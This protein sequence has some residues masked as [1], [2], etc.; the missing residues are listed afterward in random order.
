[1][2][3]LSVETAALLAILYQDRLA[4]RYPADMVSRA[5]ELHRQI[6]CVKDASP[7]CHYKRKKP[8]PV[9]RERRTLRA[10]ITN[11]RKLALASSL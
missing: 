1:M 11:G 9:F 7:R 5:R 8:L 2:R 4:E 10:N 3:L 6:T